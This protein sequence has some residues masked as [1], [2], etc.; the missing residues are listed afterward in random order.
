[1]KWTRSQVNVKGEGLFHS[2]KRENDDHD[3]NEGFKRGK[4]F[5]PVK[6]PR[7]LEPRNSQRKEREKK[8]KKGFESP[9]DR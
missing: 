9:L 5:Q 1:V 7:A 8:G 2:G 6:T 4:M 3:S